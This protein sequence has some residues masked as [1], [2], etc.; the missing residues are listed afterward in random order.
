MLDSVA[1]PTRT[2]GSGGP[3]LWELLKPERPVP[4]APL[5]AAKPAPVR[6]AEVQIYRQRENAGVQQAQART[7]AIPASVHRHRVE[8]VITRIHASLD[9]PL[10]LEEMARIA[11]LS[12]FHFDR[13]FSSLTG[14]APAAFQASLRLD[15]AKRALL[16]SERTIT[17]ICFALGYESLGSFT[18]RFTQAVGLSPAA[19][20]SRVA[21][22]KEVDMRDVLRA[23]SA[24]RE[25]EQ[26]ER[27]AIVVLL[28]HALRD[29]AIGWIGAFPK[30]IPD[31]APS[32]GA[33][34]VGNA[35]LGL[36]PLTSGTYHVLAASYPLSSNIA[37]YL[38]QQDHMRVATSGPLS[39]TNAEAI[40]VRLQL[41]KLE[42]TDPPI[43]LAL[44]LFTLRPQG[45]RSLNASSVDTV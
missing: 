28:E 16:E 32:A 29:D 20:R 27:P 7:P 39:L 12:P 14:L 30:G 45:G 42:I 2:H 8:Q 17:D 5:P 26:S 10:R 25:A 4:A 34:V 38:V 21:A 3:G 33:I 36:G 23:A 35:A 37:D 19:F 6:S 24:R 11:H 40:A 1:P 44:P 43:L 15:A 31:R 22:L 13:V 18:T 9:A 41:R